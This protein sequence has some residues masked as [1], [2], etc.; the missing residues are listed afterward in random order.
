[1]MNDL[2]CVHPHPLP[3]EGSPDADEAAKTAEWRVGD[4]DSAKTRVMPAMTMSDAKRYLRRNGLSFRTS[5]ALSLTLV[6]ALLAAVLVT[7][8]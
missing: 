3:L 1:M 8:L 4:L 6:A 7:H 5:V 2:A